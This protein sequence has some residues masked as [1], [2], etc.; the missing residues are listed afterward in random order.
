MNG[1]VITSLCCT[2]I[3][4]AMMHRGFM[5]NSHVDIK[6]LNIRNSGF[7]KSSAYGQGLLQILADGCKLDN[8]LSE[9]SEVL[10]VP[11]SNHESIYFN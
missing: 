1:R 11:F 2:L 4:I 8:P 9:I 6:L 10:V 7:H 3:A 5:R